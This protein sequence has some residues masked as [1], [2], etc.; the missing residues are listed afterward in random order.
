LAEINKLK[1]QILTGVELIDAGEY[2]EVLKNLMQFYIYDFSEYVDCDVEGDG[3]FSA[4]H[5]LDA[6]W[7]ESDD[8]FPYLVK[9]DD[10]YVGFVLVKTIKVE[11]ELFSI[12]EFFIM[13]KY[14]R[15][16]IGKAVAKKLFDRYKGWWEVH[17]R[18]NNKSA[19][20]FWRKVINEYTKSHFTEHFVN[21]KRIQ[22][23]RS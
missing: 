19:Q 15:E 13:K 14:R 21:G 22:M 1:V 8:K 12:A 20:Q 3:L 4:Y 10:K 9:K 16:G 18:E 2:K 17:Q 11:R 5:D 23:F 6:Y 7:K